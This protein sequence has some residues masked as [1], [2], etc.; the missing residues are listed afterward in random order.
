MSVDHDKEF[1]GIKQADNKMPS[2]YVISFIVSIIWGLLYLGYYMTTDFQQEE[3]FSA[4]VATHL[5][6]YKQATVD[7][8]II[9][10]FK[11]DAAGIA[12]GEK[13]YVAKC[14]ACHKPDMTGL[15]GPNLTD[16]E[17]IFGNNDTEVYNV[18]M[19]GRTVNPGKVMP[20]HK[21]VLGPKKIWEVVAFLQSKNKNIKT[22]VENTVEK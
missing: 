1:D 15:I 8:N 11:G 22:T 14:A 16:T 20:P 13:H 2:W 12:N 19:E 17:W 21:A 10:P 3:E 18:I 4:E 7:A 9:N 6:K 5:K